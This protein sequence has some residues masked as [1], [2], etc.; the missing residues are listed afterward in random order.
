[1]STGEPEGSRPSYVTRCKTIKCSEKYTMRREQK[2]AHAHCRQHGAVV[3]SVVVA[4]SHDHDCK[5]NG[6]LQPKSHCCVL[7]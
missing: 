2:T 6:L 4:T 5:V 1:M 3:R 7:G